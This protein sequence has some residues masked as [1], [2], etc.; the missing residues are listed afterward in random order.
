MNSRG[1]DL[2]PNK[3][4]TT[5]PAAAAPAAPSHLHICWNVSSVYLHRGTQASM[6]YLMSDWCICV[7]LKLRKVFVIV[8]AL[9]TASVASFPSLCL[10]PNRL[11]LIAPHKSSTA[12]L[13]LL[14]DC[15]AYL[16]DLLQFPQVTRNDCV[17][18][19]ERA[20]QRNFLTCT[21]INVTPGLT[22]WLWRWLFCPQRDKICYFD[23]RIQL[24][25]GTPTCLMFMEVESVSKRKSN[26]SRMIKRKRRR[27]RVKVG[28]EARETRWLI[29]VA[30]V[31]AKRKGR[32]REKRKIWMSGMIKMTALIEEGEGWA[33]GRDQ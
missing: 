14:S 24:F 23:G 8:G 27:R 5:A 28:I 15:E 26:K 31:E 21:N 6:F 3:I 12:C 22:E 17:G 1:R 25:R 29:D 13:C 20:G 11:L 9:S 16:H 7:Y 10:G 30:K 4:L 19:W 33:G 18:L 32:G 2:R